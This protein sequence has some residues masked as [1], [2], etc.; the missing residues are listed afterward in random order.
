MFAKDFPKI[1]E[2][3]GVK[4]DGGGKFYLNPLKKFEEQA[5]AGKNITGA[6]RGALVGTAGA[7]TGAGIGRGLSG[8][9]RGM[10]SGK[11]WAETGKAEAEMNRKM[12][13]AKLDGSTFL[14]RMGARVSGATGGISRGEMI[15]REK[16]KLETEQK[17]Y[18]DRIKSIEDKIKPTKEKIADQKRFSDSIKAMEDRAKSEIEAGNGGAIGLEYLSRKAE[19][20]RLKST[21]GSSAAAIATAQKNMIDYLNVE[22][23]KEYMT[24]ASAGR[25]SDSTFENLRKN[26]EQAGRSVG[27]ILSTDGDDIHKQYGAS[28]GETGN[29][30]RSIYDQE[31]EIS[32]LNVKKADLGDKMRDISDRERK[33]KADESVAK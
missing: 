3:L 20:E 14:G 30:E 1:L 28:K 13:Q 4:L 23:M 27:T 7:L 10:K 16:S 22:G 33:A 8:A 5:M 21:P 12:R 26:A 17:Q 19:Y 9:W 18:D 11:G 6:A 2:G 32:E 15:A 31:R 29:L 25:L 24:E